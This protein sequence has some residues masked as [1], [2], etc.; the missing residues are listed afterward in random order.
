MTL[1][2]WR[3]RLLADLATFGTVRAVAQRGN[4]SPSSVSQQLATLERETRTALLERTGRR[5]RLTAAGMLLAGRA[6]P[7]VTA[8]LNALRAGD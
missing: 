2:P 5:V 7:E 4:L 6:R 8:V 1:N 3:L